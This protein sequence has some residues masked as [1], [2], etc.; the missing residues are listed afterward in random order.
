[1]SGTTNL[2]TPGWLTFAAGTRSS[3]EPLLNFWVA[4]LLGDG[5]KVRC[6]VERLDDTG[7]VVETR[8]FPL[9][10]VSITPLDLVYGVEAANTTAQPGM[11]LSDMEQQVLYYAKHKTGGFDPLANLRLQHARP[12]NLTAGEMTLFDVLEQ[13][14]GIRRLLSVARGADPEDVNPPERTGQGTIDLTELES[15]VVRAE[16]ALNAAHKNLIALIARITTTTTAELLRAA[17]LK[18]AAFGIGPAVP[19]SAGG[20]NPASIAALARQGQALLK[21]GAARLDQG[22]ALRALPV[23]AEQRARRE[24]VVERMRAVFGQSFV[25]LPRFSFDAAGAAEFTNALAASTAAQGG[26]PL[27]VNT[28]FARCARVRDA[29]ARMGS[30][31][32]RAEVLGAAARLNLSVAQ[33]PF[34]AGERWVGLAPLSGTVMPPSKLSLVVHAVAPINTTQV[35]TGLL[36]DE[37]VEIVPNTRETTALAF[38]FD[39]PN[40]C[41]PQSV[42]IAVPPVP[43][44]D[45]TAETL[46]RVLME[47]LDLAK[48][49]AVDTGSLGAV[50]QHLPGLYLA[51]NTEDHAVSTDF[52][53]LTH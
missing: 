35:M 34:V 26:D 23:A 18:L 19:V 40:S 2:I 45:W 51:F 36:L 6:T 28:W 1:M 7:N 53:P 15:R 32:Q 46:R 8:T 27:A 37:W 50:A 24:Q 49:R 38:Q 13:A 16:N 10:E 12:T 11:S 30:C 17:L 43:G 4:K 52:A 39:V 14:R 25:V 9:S 44:Q 20:E 42:L 41:A 31:L 22:A 21:L 5:S 47:A 48:L 33:L 3:A 29:V